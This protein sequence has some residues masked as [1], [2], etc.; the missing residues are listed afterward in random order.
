TGDIQRIGAGELIAGLE[1]GHAPREAGDQEDDKQRAV[2]DGDGLLEGAGEIGA[3]LAEAA[4]H[5]GDEEGEAP[6]VAG[7]AET[8][9]A[10]EPSQVENG[11]HVRH[12]ASQRESGNS[13][14]GTARWAPW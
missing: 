2:A 11:G 5:V 3:P 8:P 4:E 1:G 9:A 6:G 12:G 7:G 13:E 14:R 10:D